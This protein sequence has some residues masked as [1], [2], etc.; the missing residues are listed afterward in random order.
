MPQFAMFQT[1]LQHLLENVYKELCGTEHW[2][3]AHKDRWKLVNFKD[4]NPNTPE[5]EGGGGTTDKSI[6]FQILL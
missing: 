2:F 6:L 3:M 5:G 1:N 4:G